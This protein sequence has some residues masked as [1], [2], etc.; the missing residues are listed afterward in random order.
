VIERESTCPDYR[1]SGDIRR[2]VDFIRQHACEGINVEDVVRHLAISRRTLEKHFRERL[3]HTPYHEIQ[4][5]R[6]ARA[7]QL[8]VDTELSVTRIAELTGFS[9]HARLT[10]FFRKQTGLSPSGFR[11]RGQA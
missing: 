3:G 4:Q 10:T 5:I 8:L 1:G 6:L 11:K 7:K 2:A 9:E